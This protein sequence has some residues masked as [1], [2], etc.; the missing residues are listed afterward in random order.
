M[1][2]HVPSM[3]KVLSFILNTAGEVGVGVCEGRQIT[4][5][6]DIRDEMWTKLGLSFSTFPLEEITQGVLKSFS[7]TVCKVFYWRL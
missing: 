4:K 7:K 6:K 2:E 1:T 3:Y 5:G